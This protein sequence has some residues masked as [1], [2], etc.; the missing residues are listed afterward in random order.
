[1]WPNSQDF[2]TFT[3]EILNGRLYLF[4][5]IIPRVWWLIP[6]CN[7]SPSV[8][9][10]FCHQMNISMTIVLKYFVLEKL[11]EVLSLSHFKVLRPSF[12]HVVCKISS[13][14]VIV[15]MTLLIKVHHKQV[16]SAQL[17]RWCFRTLLGYCIWLLSYV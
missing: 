15:S 2:V 17:S 3:E 6:L 11:H 5:G 13:F 9:K 1:M 8:C 7:L 12:Y 16:C 10:I 4:E 14:H